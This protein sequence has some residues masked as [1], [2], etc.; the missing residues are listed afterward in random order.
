MKI[1]FFGTPEFAVA[2]LD[3]I[4]E[5]GYDVAAVVTMPDRK[6]GRG[7]K[8]IE[9]DVKKYAVGKGLKI[10]QPERLKS[11][12]FL[13][14]LKEINADLFIVIA[15]RMLPKEVWS[16]PRMGTFNLHASLLPQLRGA[17][18]INHAIIEGFKETGVT[19]FMINEEIDTGG[20][21]MSA[22][23]EITEKDDAGSLHDRL[24]EMGAELTVKTIKAIE[25]GDISPKEQPS[26]IHLV[27][28]PKIFK[29][30][31]AVDFNLDSAI[32]DRKIR[33]L[34][35]YPGAWCRVELAD[36]KIVEAKILKS[37]PVFEDPDDPELK[38][39]DAI[40]KGKKLF[41]KTADGFIEILE[42]QPSGKKRMTVESFLAG[43]KPS[44]FYV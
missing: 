2:S 1:V 8:T 43:Y 5:A 3:K 27:A 31:C 22:K 39:G 37:S 44:R 41:V 17:A 4:I 15:F 33:G 36:S 13:D 20:I 21:L 35:P 24:M 25:E 42:L 34:S 6:G 14:T 19:T 16:M 28:A 9:S 32:I 40:K 30:T 11:P 12:D 7:N 38:T 26:D 10:L 29:D 23:T 18:P